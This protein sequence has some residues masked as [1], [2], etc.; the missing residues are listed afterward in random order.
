MHIQNA[1]ERALRHHGAGRLEQAACIYRRILGVDP[2]NVDALYL[3]GV[4]AYQAGDPA[5]AVEYYRRALE[6]R[7]GAAIILSNLGNALRA[8]GDPAGAEAVQREAIAADPEL[9]EAWS[10]LGNALHDRHKLAEAARAYE[11]A[12]A[13]RPDYVEAA[14]NLGNLH[15]DRGDLAA[16][17]AA[18]RR[19]LA[20]D[21]GLAQAH[22]N[23]GNALCKRR[24]FAAAADAFGRAVT[25]APDFAEAQFNLGGALRELGRHDHSVAAFDRALTIDPGY[26]AALAGKAATQLAAGDPA[27]AL[28]SCEACRRIAPDR[29]QAIAYGALALQELGRSD[30]A[31]RVNDY[32]RLICATRLDLPAGGVD[33]DRLHGELLAAIRADPTLTLEP[34]EYL[35][36][37]GRLTAN[38]LVDPVPA[39]ARFAEALRRTIDRY[40]GTLPVEPDHPY[41]A[42]I[43]KRY[44][45]KLRATLVRA[46][47]W[48]PEHLH[49][50]E[51]LS[52]VYYLEM[53]P[54]MAEHGGWI[55]FG[56]PDYA[57]P[58][59]SRL[60]FRFVRPFPGMLLLFP[61]YFFH[62]TVPFRG[63]G[64]R[65]NLAFDLS[66]AQ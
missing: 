27:S 17:V 46:G 19:V 25:L 6:L 31:R 20:I 61:S 11:R 48:H 24:D 63:A 40:F 26:A 32:D 38:L 13:L 10:N 3:L 64:E 50:H 39:V 43:P 16:A 15:K 37:G 51:W 2:G 9:P 35:T 28:A 8:L 55:E 60:E 45:L 21:P 41:L 58:A 7:P 49:E 30:D 36:R 14:F 1:T 54:D 12:I 18:W 29:Q 33:R 65:I 56:R 22:N 52:G 23:I 4:V 5:G 47:G 62:R 59:G 42:R 57:L 66:H 44:D 34:G 53:P